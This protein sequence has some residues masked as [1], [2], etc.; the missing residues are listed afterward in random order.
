MRPMRL[1]NDDDTLIV[2]KL[3]RPGDGELGRPV[4][5]R[6]LL[7]PQTAR[8]EGDQ[9]VWPMDG[10]TSKPV[11]KELLERFA[12][13][14]DGSDTDVR[15]FVRRWGPLQ[16][17]KE[18]GGT[19]A[20]Q[21]VIRSVTRLAETSPRQIIEIYALPRGTRSEPII[22]WREP[23]DAYRRFARMAYGL[24]RCAALWRQD[25]QPSPEDWFM[26]IYGVPGVASDVVYDLQLIA[27]RR[28]HPAEHL[29]IGLSR[30]LG[31]P[32]TL[33]T[34]QSAA[35]VGKLQLGSFNSLVS[36]LGLQL[37]AAVGGYGG[38]GFCSECGV[39]FQRQDKA[40]TRGKAEYCDKHRGRA[41]SRIASQKYWKRNAKEIIRRRRE[42]RQA[43]RSEQP[44]GR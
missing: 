24:M 22:E 28:K 38:T 27:R 20:G 5:L 29:W 6:A 23:I 4:A 34:F 32:C 17:C 11:G 10:L 12:R 18:E 7:V 30:W 8:I 31:T 41:A 33:E 26:A 2:S 40:V 14:R 13:L 44:I 39:L 21:V 16:Y 37:A 43:R 42:R 9:V 35:Q 36:A 19:L 15:D 1:I 25:E 3:G